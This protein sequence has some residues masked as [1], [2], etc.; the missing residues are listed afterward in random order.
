MET[1]AKENAAQDRNSPFPVVTVMPMAIWVAELGSLSKTLLMACDLLIIADH[2]P[3]PIRR[4]KAPIIA[5]QT[6]IK[7]VLRFFTTPLKRVKIGW[8]VGIGLKTY[9]NKD[10]AVERVPSKINP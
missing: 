8:A 5:Q 10:T 3:A 2:I 7:K 6:A 4:K 9:N 1:K